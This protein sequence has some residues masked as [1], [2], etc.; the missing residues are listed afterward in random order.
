MSC[1]VLGR[2]VEKLVYN[3]LVDAGRAAG[4]KELV[5]RYVPTAKNELVKDLY[6][7]LGFSPE[8]GGVWR[9]SLPQAKLCEVA[10][11]D[12]SQNPPPKART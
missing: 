6:G 12:G 3:R 2:D 11:T 5:G 7:S 1:R 10:I 4:A 9:L 8:A